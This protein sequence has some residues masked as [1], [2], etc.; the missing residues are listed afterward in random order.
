MTA[1]E[2]RRRR[3]DIFGTRSSKDCY[4]GATRNSKTIR[5]TWPVSSTGQKEMSNVLEK[6]SQS[7]GPERLRCLDEYCR[8]NRILAEFPER[9]AWNVPR[10]SD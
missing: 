5:R 1:V 6:A 4:F 2:I 7:Q 10:A 9:C 8:G 3:T